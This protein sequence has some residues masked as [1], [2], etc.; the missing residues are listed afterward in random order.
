MLP[1]EFGRTAVA[2]EHERSPG[3][4]CQK[5]GLGLV[6]ILPSREQPLPISIA[7]TREL[8]LTGSFR[9][10]DDSTKSS[11]LSRTRRWT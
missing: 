3:E 4:M 8:T 10:N 6:G 7:I 2:L 1:P 9:R 5:G 11:R